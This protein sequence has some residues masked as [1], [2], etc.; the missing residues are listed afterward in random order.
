VEVVATRSPAGPFSA[1][2]SRVSERVM[3]TRLGLPFHMALYT[4]VRPSGAKRAEDITDR[5][6]SDVP[7]TI[8]RSMGWTGGPPAVGCN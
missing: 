2:D 5:L 6:R 3:N 7:E 4:I 8:R 1:L